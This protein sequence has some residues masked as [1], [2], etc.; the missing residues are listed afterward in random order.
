MKNSY[1]DKIGLNALNASKNLSLLNEK[2]KK[3]KIKSLKI[4]I[5]ILNKT[6]K[7]F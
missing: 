2:K 1:L 4:S 7:K 3:K 5:R 6:K